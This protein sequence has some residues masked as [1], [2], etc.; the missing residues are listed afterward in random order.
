MKQPASVWEAPKTYFSGKDVKPVLLQLS[1][2]LSLS[3]ILGP[4]YIYDVHM[5]EG[6]GVGVQL[7]FMYCLFFTGDLEHDTNFMLQLVFTVSA[8]LLSFIGKRK[9]SSMGVQEKG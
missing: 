7:I 6:C 2:Q 9:V 4:I 8:I 3:F 5:E 1:Y